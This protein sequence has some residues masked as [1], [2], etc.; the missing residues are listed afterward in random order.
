MRR[1]YLLLLVAIP[2]FFL[3]VP[4]TVSGQKRSAT[5]WEYKTIIRQR[6]WKPP[7]GLL[8]GRPLYAD[9]WSEWWEDGASIPGTADMNKKL[10][11]LGS[12]G[13]ELV[14]VVPRSGM[15]GGAGTT[16]YAGFTSEDLWI[17]K[18]PKP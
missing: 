6:S 7:E 18:R 15:M 13:W 1:R 14:A 12:S 10:P 5:T 3:A 9:N 8:S 4:W 16:D 11:E 17:F 2:L